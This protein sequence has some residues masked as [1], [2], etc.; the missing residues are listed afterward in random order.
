MKLVT[1]EQMRKIDR[2]AIDNRGIPGP[3]LMENAGRGIAKL[4]IQYVSAEGDEPVKAAIFCGKG[5]NGGD[6]FVVGRY[7][8]EAGYPITI[9]FMGPVDKLSPDGRLNYDR[10][11]D[12]KIELVEVSNS[13]D[14]PDEIDDGFIVDAIF[15]IG[16]SGA[17]RGLAA[18]IIDFI[19]SQ[20][21]PVFAVDLPSG[22]NTDA[23]QF[24]GA[25]V[26]ADC[27]F[28]LALP[29]YGLFVTPGRELAGEV[30]IVP[31]GIPDDVIDG[32][33]L[34]V[35]LSTVDKIA[36]LLPERRPDGHKGDFGK[37]F[38]L[39][40]STNFIGAAALAG[41]S[42]LRSGCGLVKIGCPQSVQPMIAS[43]IAEA[44]FQ[45]LPD[46]GKKGVLALRGLGEVR[47]QA[48]EHDALAI[49]PGIGQHHE[50]KELILRLLPS[51]ETPMVV[52]ADGLNALVG[53]LEILNEVKAPLVLTPH[54]GEFKRLVGEAVPVEIHPR[55]EMA[56]QFAAQ[57]GVTLVLKG[58][59]TIVAD[60]DGACFLNPTGNEGMATGG[61]GDV[62][63]GIIGSFLA[64]GM[65]AMDAAVTGVF[66]HGMCGYFAAEDLT[67]R[68]M[69][70]GDLVDYLPQ[71]YK[72]LDGDDLSSEHTC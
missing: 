58:S 32:F 45:P 56:R 33:N 19:N 17:P 51:V 4:I 72:Y 50:T 9:Y 29:K 18:E 66:V 5:N 43:H 11:L 8:H 39:A 38:V 62:L 1:A 64:Q 42:A 61:S 48:R 3:E 44:T 30:L 53:S 47:L 13:A 24:E 36:A 28:T 65:A 22:L 21:L 37:L 49:G 70:A 68:A 63:T 67:T 41:H 10:A 25:V 14:L 12:L 59:P 55:I 71:T 60:K 26:Q 40:G 34:K 46:V 23:G 52:D 69:I 57:Y 6:G 16:F 54:P 7:L 31:I 15:G 27:T 35:E 20:E 2:E